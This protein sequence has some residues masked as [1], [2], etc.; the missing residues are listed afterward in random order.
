MDQP[1]PAEKPCRECGAIKP[2]E[3]F[4]RKLDKR[5]PRCKDCMNRAERERR[6]QD[7]ER[8]RT[9]ERER[10]AQGGRE[11]K[12][13]SARAWYA[14]NRQYN[15]DR[16]REYCRAN[17]EKI[18]GAAARWRADNPER[19]AEMGRADAAL[20]RARKKT[21][22]PAERLTHEAIGSRDNWMCGLCDSA[23]DPDFRWPHPMSRVLDHII[24]LVRGGSHTEENVRIAH[25]LCNARKGARLDDELA[26]F[27][28]DGSITCRVCKQ[29]KT[30]SGFYRA[31]AARNGYRTECKK[32]WKA[33]RGGME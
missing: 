12:L 24:P 19:A 32:C 30:P 28:A 27:N 10:Y 3:C 8:I 26:L 25:W 33:S 9:R 15:I 22:G 16:R 7:P 17:P 14:R 13:A 4:A 23:V 2:I 21:N 6:A 1:S 29:D 20:R 11:S 31:S 5:V 18:A